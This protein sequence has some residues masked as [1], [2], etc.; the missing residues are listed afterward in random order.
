MANTYVCDSGITKTTTSSWQRFSSTN[1]LIDILFWLT[2]E[3][4]MPPNK[5][6]SVNTKHR[7]ISTVVLFCTDPVSKKHNVSTCTHLALFCPCNLATDYAKHSVHIPNVLSLVVSTHSHTFFHTTTTHG[8]YTGSL[9][10]HING[11]SQ[12]GHSC[13]GLN[14]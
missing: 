11:R 14:L 9:N 8:I 1:W 5:T 7:W 13:H 10:I 12:N 2:T 4:D 3:S 6:S